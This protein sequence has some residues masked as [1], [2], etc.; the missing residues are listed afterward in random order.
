MMGVYFLIVA[1]SFLSQVTSLVDNHYKVCWDVELPD[2]NFF[3]Y[4]SVSLTSLN[5]VDLGYLAD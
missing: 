2:E 4:G 5:P 3:C 1:L